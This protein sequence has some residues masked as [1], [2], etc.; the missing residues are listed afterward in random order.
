MKATLLIKAEKPV[1]YRLLTH[2]DGGQITNYLFT[3]AQASVN[4]YS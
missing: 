1:N 3:T 2:V 4:S